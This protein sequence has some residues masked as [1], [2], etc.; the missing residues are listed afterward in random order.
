MPEK[1]EAPTPHRL[2]KARTEGQ[3][4]QSAEVNTAVL[5]IVAFWL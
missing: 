3:V 5:L 2:A 1:T 4:A